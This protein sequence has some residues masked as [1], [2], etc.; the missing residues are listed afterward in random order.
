VQA[1]VE[2]IDRRA[3]WAFRRV[4]TA[5]TSGKERY[6]CPARAGK[7]R[8]PL[9]KPSMGKP[10]ALPT[11]LHPP[12]EN[13]PTCCTQRTITVPGDV[14]AKNRQRHYWG[15]RDWISAYARRSRVEGWFGNAKSNNA[16]GLTRGAFRVMGIAKTSLMLGIYAAATNLRLL[17]AWTARHL[18]EHGSNGRPRPQKAS[19][20]SRKMN[21][22]HPGAGPPA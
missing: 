6:E 4:T 13:P 17:R 20:P 12:V 19:T 8:C 1:F 18:P 11:T 9:Y 2:Q 15:S 7:V 21:R 5:D 16:E 3:R 22:R 10:L 14:D